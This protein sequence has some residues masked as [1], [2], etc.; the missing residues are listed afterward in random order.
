[1]PWCW[2]G[3]KKSIN[4]PAV[5][6]HL[7]SGRCSFSGTDSLGRGEVSWICERIGVFLCCC[8]DTVGVDNVVFLFSGSQAEEEEA[9]EAEPIRFGI[10]D[11]SHPWA[12]SYWSISGEECRKRRIR[13]ININTGYIWSRASSFL[14]S[15]VV[16]IGLHQCFPNRGP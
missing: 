14:N 7:G 5:F 12:R 13:W 1:M 10:Q 6:G 15:N 8:F 4:K 2:H 3:V 9:A 11:A 16:L